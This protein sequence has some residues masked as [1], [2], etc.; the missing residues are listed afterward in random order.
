MNTENDHKDMTIDGPDL[1]IDIDKIEV[2]ISDPDSGNKAPHE[3]EAEKEPDESVDKPEAESK[4]RRGRGVKFGMVITVSVI[5]LIA[6][7]LF[8]WQKNHVISKVEEK[9]ETLTQ[10]Y[11]KIEPII[12]NLDENKRIKISLM[13]RYNSESVKQVSEVDSSIRN[14]ILMF[15]TSPNT[16]ETIKSYDSVML[17]SYIENEVTRIVKDEYIDEIIFSEIK[18]Y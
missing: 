7:F 13:I 18:V 1:G 8:F 16:K 9:R 11:L 17:R 2:P 15:L 6:G 14:D 3:I 5:A 12:T 10:T 4:T